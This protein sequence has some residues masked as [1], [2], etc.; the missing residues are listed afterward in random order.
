VRFP[1][2]LSFSD[3]GRLLDLS[4]MIWRDTNMIGYR[5]NGG[6]RPYDLKKL[7][8][9]LGLSG[10]HCQRFIGKMIGLGIIRHVEIKMENRKREVQY[11]MNPLYFCSSKRVSLNLYL[12]FRDQL[13]PFL[14]EW[15]KVKFGEQEAEKRI[16]ES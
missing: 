16:K 15:V 8:D 1:E 7:A 12:L 5:G 13:N 6:G 4:K 2:E 10:R 14:P 9:V 11:Y 3:K